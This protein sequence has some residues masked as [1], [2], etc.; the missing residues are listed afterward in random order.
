MTPGDISRLWLTKL[1]LSFFTEG[2][3][4]QNL[5]PNR[6]VA[7]YI[8]RHQHVALDTGTICEHFTSVERVIL[9]IER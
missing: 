9:S 2:H 4:S 7:A 1:G 3:R 6:D 8:L 5:V